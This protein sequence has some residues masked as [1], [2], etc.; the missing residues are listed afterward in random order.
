MPPKSNQTLPI[1]AVLPD[2]IGAVD[3]SPATVL[4]AAPGAGKSTRVPLSLLENA[5]F[6]DATIIML[7]PRRLA[8]RMVAER[9]AKTLGESVGQ[10]VGYRVRNEVKVSAATR[11][12]VVTEGILT[13]RLQRD[14]ELEGT[15]LVIFDE[16]HERSI[17]ADLGLAL[18]LDVQRSLRPDLKILVMSATIDAQSTSAFL[19]GARVIESGHRPHPVETRYRP[20]KTGERTSEAVAAAVRTALREE[21][22]SLLAFLPG[23]REIRRCA[24][25]LEAGAS[26][27]V[28]ICP[29]FGA[30][31]WDAQTKAVA[32]APQG[33]RKVVLATTIAE[34]SLTI[35][36]V[37]IVVDS[38]DKRVSRFDVRRGMAEL[39]TVKIS[40]AA[41]EQR[42]GRAGR[43]GPG[44]CYRLWAEAEDRAR[45]AF[46]VP[47]MLQADLAPLA[48]DLAA[49]G[50][51]D[52]SSLSWLTPPPEAALAQARDLLRALGAIDIDGRITPD[53]RAMADLPL[54]PRLAHVVQRGSA[55]GYGPLA[56]DVAAVLAERDIPGLGDA[57]LRTRLALFSGDVRAGRH[58][59][60]IMRI[61]ENAKQIGRIAGISGTV[62]YYS[63][64]G[65]LVALAYPDRVAQRRGG[66]GRFRLS[67]GGSAIIDAADPLAGEEYLAVASSDGTARDAR[68]YL[69]APLGKTDI[70]LV[71]GDQ[72]RDIDEV[73]WNEQQE[74]VVA[75]HA[76]KFGALVLDEKP[77]RDADPEKTVAAM[78]TGI[79][80]MGLHALPW[81][82]AAHSFC[83]R[84]QFVRRVTADD[85]WPDLSDGALEQRL[86]DWLGPYL[87]GLSRRTHLA[88]LDMTSILSNQ[89]DW[90]LRARLDEFAPERITVP[91]GS[92]IKVDYAAEAGPSIQVKLQEVFGMVSTPMVAGGRAPVT[93]HLLSPAMRPIAVTADLASFWK[94]AYP[95]V[96]G[97]MRGRY[98][99]H[100]WPENPLTAAPSR[101]SIKPR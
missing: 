9:M 29:L 22:G 71:F 17:D 79:R 42:R 69:G 68:I 88:K 72:I 53:G 73:V 35:E 34:T 37:R 15:G 78:C 99:R 96:R 44:V 62:D 84:V 14:P 82:E 26:D 48:L 65:S 31:P 77:T 91:S 20:S 43:L 4:V 10:T 92:A 80:R 66:S 7:E 63:A 52:A 54:H 16:F 46:D 6:A 21:P 74:A 1:D 25:A 32:P 47:E 61:R 45:P 50:V 60:A 56:R 95:Q 36:G 2:V 89:I 101:R 97:E 94:N 19:G 38:G 18:V 76:R 93:L 83:Y 55:L 23:E 27:D 86:E 8:A 58:R 39:A 28:D 75:R 81:T 70:E 59:G 51:T 49:W 41:A 87:A 40:R 100:N 24:E 64:A 11:I 13:R 3:A 5:H 90:P 33:R 67:G 98:P 57:D 30:L 12:E 85:S